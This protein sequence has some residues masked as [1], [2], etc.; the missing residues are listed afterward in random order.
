MSSA[1]QSRPSW[2][3]PLKVLMSIVYLRVSSPTIALTLHLPSEIRSISY[4]QQSRETHQYQHSILTASTRMSS[5]RIIVLPTCSICQ[6]DEAGLDIVATICG[7]VFHL[8]CIRTWDESQFSRRHPTKCPSCNITLR[9]AAS[10]SSAARFITLHSLTEREVDDQGSSQVIARTGDSSTDPRLSRCR[11]ELNSLKETLK[12]REQK[13]QQLTLEPVALRRERENLT[14][15]LRVLNHS[16]QELE[17]RVLKVSRDLRIERK[18]RT[19]ERLAR[20]LD[21]KRIK[22]EMDKLN[23]KYRIAKNEGEQLHEQ[24]VKKVSENE[25]LQSFV[26]E[27]GQEKARFQATEVALRAQLQ[28]SI[29]RFKSVKAANLVYKDKLEKKRNF[30]EDKAGMGDRSLTSSVRRCSKF[31]PD[32]SKSSIHPGGLMVLSS[33]QATNTTSAQPSK[34][35]NQPTS[36]QSPSTESSKRICR[37]KPPADHHQ[38]HPSAN[39]QIEIQ[40]S[41]DP[42]DLTHHNHPSSSNIHSSS[43]PPNIPADQDLVMPSLFG[44][45][46]ST[47]ARDQKNKLPLPF[48]HLRTNQASS[49]SAFKFSK[50]ADKLLALGPKVRHR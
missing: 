45:D 46:L 12:E 37:T 34:R 8:S 41:S 49:S 25:E 38:N 36:V 14:A 21:E 48:N 39:V 11:E 18:E 43:P 2:T 5:S 50:P 31:Y 35:A 9:R 10:T 22:T 19:D 24:Y 42:E 16:K 7:H 28:E 29:E 6:D 32:V 20:S 33:N 17:D 15:T 30:F 13:I 3:G 27:F 47:P 44:R 23:E 26:S 1:I 40:S 4:K